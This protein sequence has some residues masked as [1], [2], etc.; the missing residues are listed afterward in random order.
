LTTLLRALGVILVLGGLAH[1]VGV[2]HL[3]LAQGV[4]DANRIML[5]VWIAEAQLLSGGL[6]LAA[7][8]GRRA[9]STWRA[10]AAFGALTMIGFAAPILPILVS[11]APFIFRVPAIVYLTLSLVILAAAASAGRRGHDVGERGS[12]R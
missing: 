10:L 8:R 2:T 3:Y 11:R 9:G 6:Y 4:P 1:S 7:W 12:R 5:D